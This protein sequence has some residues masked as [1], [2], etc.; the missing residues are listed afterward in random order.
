MIVLLLTV[1]N[2]FYE[3]APAMHPGRAADL[4][5][6]RAREKARLGMH[7][8]LAIVTG[9]LGLSILK[10]LAEIERGS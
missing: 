2:A 1:E 4:Q 3:K 6:R 8:R 10:K 9:N 5:S 7:V